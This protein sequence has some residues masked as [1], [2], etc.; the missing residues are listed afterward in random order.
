MASRYATCTTLRLEVDG[1]E[2]AYLSRRFVPLPDTL[3]VTQAQTATASTRVD[4][5]AAKQLGSP[6]A[7]WRL[8]DVNAAPDLIAVGGT[9]GAV[10]LI[11]S[12]FQK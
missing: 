2:V 7:S 8:A 1:R 11:S 5:I 3:I 6:T 9:P 10:V 4:L 12:P